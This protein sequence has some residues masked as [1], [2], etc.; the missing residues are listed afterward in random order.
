MHKKV[1]N[2]TTENKEAK[3]NKTNNTTKNNKNNTLTNTQAKS[4]NAKQ[5]VSKNTKQKGE[6]TQQNNNQKVKS[7][8]E[9]KQKNKPQTKSANNKGKAIP[10]KEKKKTTVK[11]KVKEEIEQDIEII[12]RDEKEEIIKIDDI[13]ETI[14]T[15]KTIPEEEIREI[16]KHLFRN[17][18]GAVIV[19]TYFIFINLGF[20]NIKTEVYITD[21]KVFSL[22]I[23][24]LAIT[25]FEYA[26]KNEN[27][28]FAIHGI[29]M[30]ILSIINVGLIYV[31]LMLSSRYTVIVA[32]ISFIFAIY[33]L[34]KTIVIYFRS[35]KKYFID[36]MKEIM[37]KE[38]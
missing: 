38:E 21:L 37:K 17:I 30:L 20:I 28:I 36:N 14:K 27:G 12:Q 16:N 18:L 22:C 19:I 35:R 4:K 1:E 26:Y 11:G 3:G 6:N 32:A 7:N 13:K 31:N 8:Q 25:L 5:T 24:F 15:K 10:K 29:E 2:K 33:Y 23:L 34:L 9:I